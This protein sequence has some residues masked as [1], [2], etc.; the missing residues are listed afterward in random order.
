MQGRLVPPAGRGIQFFPFEEWEREFASAEE[1]GLDEIEFIF[2]EDQHERNP[3]WSPEGVSQ[4]RRLQE[5]HGVWVRHICAD[6]FMRSPFFRVSEPVRNANVAVLNRLIEVAGRIGAKTVEIPLLDNSSIRTPEEELL[7][8]ESLGECL[9]MAEQRD[10]TLAL[11]TDL[12]A[13]RLLALVKRTRSPR[14]KVV[15]DSG[16]SASL[17]YNNYD[18]IMAYGD[19]VSNVHIKDRIRGGSTVELGAGDADFDGLFRG[20]KEKKY[21]GGFILQS[22]RGEEG[23]ERETVMRHK[24]FTERYIKKYFHE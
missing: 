24:E 10:I 11:E 13:E 23:K 2:D 16:N 9:E 1:L 19:I 18:E 15:Y 4:I 7:F 6:Y 12:P 5:H 14:V 20:L 3:L 22:A 8:V 21:A 17:G